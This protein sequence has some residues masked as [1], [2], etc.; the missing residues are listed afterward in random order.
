MKI[1]IYLYRFGLL[2]F[3]FAPGVLFEEP[4]KTFLNQHHDQLTNMML[5]YGFPLLLGF[6][7]LMM[8]R[9]AMAAPDKRIANLLN[10]LAGLTVLWLVLWCVLWFGF[11]G[12]VGNP[13]DLVVRYLTRLDLLGPLVGAA[14]YAW[15]WRSADLGIRT[16]RFLITM[17][18]CVAFMSMLNLHLDPRMGHLKGPGIGGLLVMVGVYLILRENKQAA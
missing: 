18:W 8:T 3:L 1:G 4:L 6:T 16:S 2:G 11:A 10:V 15:G 14:G 13:D 7:L 12:K 5:L 9:E 17:G